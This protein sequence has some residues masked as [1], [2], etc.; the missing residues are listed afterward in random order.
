MQGVI[1]MIEADRK[2]CLRCSGCVGVCPQAALNLR[3]HGLECDP[4][5][6]VSCGICT[7]FCPVGALK[8]SD[9]GS[10]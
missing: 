5:R 7:R 4:E 3:E 8:L 1:V 6:C 9:K 10:D 2:L